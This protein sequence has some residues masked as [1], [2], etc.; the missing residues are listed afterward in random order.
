MADTKQSFQLEDLKVD[1]RMWMRLSMPVGKGKNLGNV[2]STKGNPFHEKD[3][4]AMERVRKL[5]AE[6]KLFMREEGRSRHFRKVELDGETLKL[7]EKFEASPDRNSDPVYGLLMRT[8]RAYFKWLGLDGIS[9]WFG[10]RAENYDAVQARSNRYK[11]EY[12]ALSSEEKSELKKLRKQEK[13]EEK[14]RKKLKK[15]EKEAAKAREELDQILGKDAP[16]KDEMENLLSNPPQEGEKKTSMQPVHLGDDPQQ[17]RKQE[18]AKTEQTVQTEQ[19]DPKTEEKKKEENKSDVRMTFNGQEYTKETVKEAPAEVQRMFRMME[20][21]A[22]Q[23]RNLE[24]QKATPDRQEMGVNTETAT[25]VEEGIGTEAPVTNR[26][27]LTVESKVVEVEMPAP[28]NNPPDP[29]KDKVSIH[30][31][32]PEAGSLKERLAEEE[33]RMDAVRNWK[34]QIAKALFSHE[35]G[36]DLM[37][38]YGLI[39]DDP[40]TAPIYLSTVAFSVLDQAGN[41]PAVI[42]K[43]LQGETL[44]SAYDAK[45][46]SGVENATK[47]SLD[48]VQGNE[49]PLEELLTR[50][51]RQLSSLASQEGQLSERHVMIGRLISNA[52]GT[53][54]ANE[55]TLPLN[56]REMAA[57]QGAVE[58]AKIAR[59]YHDAR[60]YLGNGQLDM[61]SEK[62]AAAVRDLLTGTAVNT[63]IRQ[64]RLSGDEINS[65]QTLMG[66]GVWSQEN[67]AQ[68]TN[69]SKAR[70]GIKPQQIEKLLA[71]PD[72]ALAHK[73]AKSVIDEVVV[74]TEEKYKAQQEVAQKELEQPV[75]N[76]MQK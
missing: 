47:V 16:N 22:T 20:E 68:M 4:A 60:Q 18:P 26:N 37:A 13:R 32:P 49:K 62:G 75:R 9:G 39:K 3:N 56:E 58:L 21:L 67:L 19:K 74:E 29:E 12:K 63:M 71:K 35:E 27:P 46:R 54:E 23:M 48:N 8:S 31:R 7:G 73:A 40:Q 66:T 34:E 42:D 64:D 43:L 1:P 33:Q 50:T 59:N 15:L 30:G 28:L 2:F 5:A 14:A 41:D 57:A 36:A 10:K 6:G 17:E 38:N 44:G 55:I 53:A 24:Q 61:T 70:K 72:S 51:V 69:N 25:M 11:E 76:L 65:C 45:I 52:M